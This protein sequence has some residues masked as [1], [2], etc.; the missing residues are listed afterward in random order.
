MVHPEIGQ[1]AGKR[2]VA[3]DEETGEKEIA[4]S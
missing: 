1:V 2:L 3:G 4:S